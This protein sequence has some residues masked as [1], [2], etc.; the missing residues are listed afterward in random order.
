MPLV[1]RSPEPPA[2][3]K[4]PSRPD[5]LV[6]ELR[7]PDPE[8]RRHAAR[9]LGAHPEAVAPI[10]GALGTEGDPAAREAMFT[11]LIGIRNAEVVSSLLPFLRSEDAALRNGAA[12]ALATMPEL[13][14]THLAGLLGDPD[15]DTRIMATEL[16]R[17]QPVETASALLCGML[18]RET[19]PNACGAALDVLAELGTPDALPAIRRVAERFAGEPFL[20]FA[21]SVAIARIEGGGS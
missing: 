12:D 8:A 1:R 11:A 20:C 13:V 15:P 18:E 21:A 16:V 10:A 2:A 6:S 9:G 7:S 3:E 4:A 14:E 5:D 19:H 17:S